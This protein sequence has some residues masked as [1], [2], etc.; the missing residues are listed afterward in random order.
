MVRTLIITLGLFFTLYA[1]S[2]SQTFDQDDEKYVV[3]YLFPQD[4]LLDP[5]EVE[6]EKLTHINYAFA[7]IRDGKIAQ[8]FEYDDENFKILNNMKERNPDLKL[9]ISVGGWTWSGN[10]SDMAL[11]KESRKKFID[12]SIEFIKQHK[13]DGID[14]D[15]EYPNMVGAGN[16][17][18]TED[19]QN[20]TLLLKELRTAL[21]ELGEAHNKHYLLTI[22]AGVSKQYIANTE[23]R[24]VQ[25]Y[26]DFVNLMTYDFYVV[27]ADSI[28][29]HNAALYTHPKDPRGIS[30][31]AGVQWFMEAGVPSEKIVLGVPFYGRSAQTLSEDG[32]GLFEP[33]I[34]PEKRYRTSFSNIKTK[35]ENKN[36]FIRYWDSAASVPYLFNE[37]E[38]VLI[39]YED[40]ESLTKKT[41]Y[42][43]EHNLKGAMFWEYQSDYESRLLNI[44]HNQ[45][46]RR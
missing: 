43:K 40:E 38:K 10:F 37:D 34:P 6:V 26:L 36:G 45:L 18:R 25:K 7:D 27:S 30:A 35:L 13:L 17:Y 22:A 14:L 5:N 2:T 46:I 32:H 28:A 1:C 12:S 9:L 42:I 24:E 4:R 19:K 21:D 16:V 44:L 3:G 29:G 20:F 33:A 39:M 11:T 31:D 8:G 41:E 15:W 23:M